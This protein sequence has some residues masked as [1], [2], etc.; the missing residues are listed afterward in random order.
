LYFQASVGS[1]LPTVT[2]FL[3]DTSMRILSLILLASIGFILAGCG[4]G[5]SSDSYTATITVGPT[6]H[7]CK[8]EAAANSCKA[9]DCSQCQC[10][11]GCPAGPGQAIALACTF[12]D[13]VARVPATGCTVATTPNRTLVCAAPKLYVLNGVGYTREQ[14]L[15]G[16]SFE[17]PNPQQLFGL[18]FSCS[19]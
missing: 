1:L 16:V 9:G 19:S 8:S 2:Q 5:G 15:A 17:G 13:G 6:S 18:S 14:V 12:V 3:E 7:V 11:T 4:G 10:L